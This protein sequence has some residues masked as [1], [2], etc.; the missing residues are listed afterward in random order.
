M[1]FSWQE[2]EDKVRK[3]VRVSGYGLLTCHEK[4]FV[5]KWGE[6]CVPAIYTIAGYALLFCVYAFLRNC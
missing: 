4:H 5:A 3:R 6:T 2:T 1:T